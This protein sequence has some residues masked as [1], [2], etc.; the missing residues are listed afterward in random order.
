MRND[1]LSLTSRKVGVPLNNIRKRY[2][3]MGKSMIIAIPSEFS[4]NKQSFGKAILSSFRLWSVYESSGIIGKMRV[5]S[6]KIISGISTEVT[7]KENG[8]IYRLDPMKV[9]FS[10]G[11][12]NE[13]RRIK[14]LMGSKE[15]VL[16]M[17]A[18]I[19]YF[20][21]PVSFKA[22]RVLACEINP[23]SFHYLLINKR[24]N[25]A[26]N[27]VPILGNSSRLRLRGFADR[28]LMGHFD[29]LDYFDKALSYLRN[30]G[31]I[32]VHQ[33]VRRGDES[34]LIEK[35]ESLEPV[36]AV[37]IHNVKSYAPGIDHDV[38]DV[39]VQKK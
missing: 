12:K 19:G 14:E 21:I 38:L 33:L 25:D 4:N 10:K 18:G 7:H 8:V 5:P 9:M 15:T 27:L 26:H 36:I 6:L 2:Q 17:Y 11:N 20:S 37:E 32:H 35:F 34:S 28:I 30:K 16:D 1:A 31:H 22:A 13:R 23:D 24:L 39:E 3:V 29:S